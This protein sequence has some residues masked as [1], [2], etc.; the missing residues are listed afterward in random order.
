MNLQIE[1]EQHGS[2]LMTFL[3][4]LN[5]TTELRWKNSNYGEILP[6]YDTLPGDEE[7][8][9]E[10]PKLLVWVL[11]NSLHYAIMGVHP[12]LRWSKK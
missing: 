4:E 10:H 12:S 1:Q 11:D 7:F 2:Y 3:R 8:F 9:T 5:R 6:G